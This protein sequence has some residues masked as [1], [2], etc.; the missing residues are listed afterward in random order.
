[1]FLLLG[2]MDRYYILYNEDY[3]NY[4]LYIG[5]LILWCLLL[6]KL[7]LITIMKQFKN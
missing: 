3:R 5:G 2:D 1:M 6:S 4:K 7:K